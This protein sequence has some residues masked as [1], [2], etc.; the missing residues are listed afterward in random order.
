MTMIHI[1]RAQDDEILGYLDNQ[2]ANN[3]YYSA[4]HEQDTEGK[5]MLV[6]TMPASTDVA[7]HIEG[8]VR[9]L[10]Q[11]E[12]GGWMEFIAFEVVTIDD[13]KEVYALGVEEDLNKLK[14]IVPRRYESYTLKQYLQIATAGTQYTIGDVEYD[15]FRTLTLDDYMGGYDF[16]R[17]VA[18][19]FDVELSYRVEVSGNKIVKRYIDVS[20]SMGANN[21]KEIVYG[22]DLIGIKKVEYSDRI[23]TSLFCI[24]PKKADGTRITTTVTDEDAFQRWNRNGA[25]LT[26]RYE[27]EST[28]E[29]MTIAQLQAYGT[30]ELKKRIDSIDEYLVTGVSIEEIYPNEKVRLG[31]DV[32]V[33]NIEYQ[34]PLYADARVLSV[35]RSLIDGDEKDY[36]IGNVFAHDVDDVLAT[37]RTMQSQYGLRIIKSVIAPAGNSSIIWVKIDAA[38]G[39]EIA[40]TWNGDEWI[41]ASPTTPEQ[42]GAEP[43]IP[44]QPTPPLNPKL[45]DKWVDTSVE[46]MELK[47]YNGVEWQA[48]QGPRGQDGYTPVKGTDY[49]DGEAGQ[50]GTD[51]T[52]SYVWIRYSQNADGSAMTTSPANAKYIGVATSSTAIVPT[53]NLSYQWSLVKGTDG[54]PGET[55]PNGQTSYIHIKYSDNGTSFTANNG[56]TVGT[57]IGIYVDFVAADSMTFSAYTW[58]KVKGEQGI[59]GPTGSQGLQGIQ[60]YEGSQG[61]QG[62]VGANGV[63]SYTHIAYSTSPTGA[64]G[65]SIGDSVGATYIGI[66][67]DSLAQDSVNPSAY[68]WTLIKGSDGTQGLPGVK[69]D[70]G[71]TPYFHTAWATNSNG[72]LGFSTTVAT[73][74]TYIGTYTDNTAADSTDPSKYTWMLTKGETGATGSQGPI[75]N[76]GLQGVQGPTGNTGIKGDTGANGQTSYTHIAYSTNATGGTGF[77]VSD[78]TG[79]TYIGM[80][81]DF[82]ATD[83]AD[84]AKYAWSLIKGADGG[85]GVAGPTGPTGQTPYLH[86][87]YSTNAT[88]TTGFS[89]TDPVG[90]THIGTY[91]DFISTD[92]STPSLYSWSLIKGDTG[93]KGD[94]GSIGPIG[95]TGPQGSQGVVGPT[96]PTGATL[97]T[98]IKYAD[99]PTTGMVDTPTGKTYI[100]LAYNKSISTE[101]SVYTD[102]SW[103]L[104][105][106][107]IGAEG[108]KGTTG[109]TLYTWIKYADTIAGAGLTDLPADKEY[110]GI[111]YN[112]SVAAESTI[113]TDYTWSLIQGP[114]G[115]VGPTGPIG[116]QGQQGVIGPTGPNG[117]TLYTWIKYADTPTTGMADVPTGKTYIGL[118]YNKTTATETGTYS[119][120]AWSLIKGDIGAEG[121]KGTTGATL[122]TWIKYADTVAG[123]GLVDVP[124]GKKYIGIAYNKSVAAES[125][126]AADYSWSLIQGDTGAVGPQGPL[127]PQGVI[128]PAGPQGVPSYT[129]IK[130]ATTPTTGMA[131][132]PTGKDYIGL[133]H[134]KTIA[135]ESS[136]YADYTWSLIKGATGSEGP[137]GPGGAPTYTWVKYADTVT[138]GG[139]SDSPTGKRFLGL[140]YNKS[141]AAESVIPTDYQWSPLYDNITVGGKNLLLKSGE[142]ITN[143]SYPIQTYAITEAIANTMEVTLSFKGTLGRTSWG[144]YNSGGGVILVTLL[145]ADKGT[146]GIFRKTFNWTVGAST[147][148]VLH[149]YPMPSTTAIDSTIEWI[150]LEKGNVA[151]D[152]TPSPQDVQIQLDDKPA[153]AD[154]EAVQKSIG[155]QIGGMVETLDG[156]ANQSDLNTVNGQ[157][158]ITN[159]AIATQTQRLSTVE[160]TADGVKS[161]ITTMQVTLNENAEVIASVETYMNFTE[162]GLEIGKSDS[163]MKVN[164][165]NTEIQFNDNGATVAY[166]NGQ[167]LY[168]TESEVLESLIIGNHKFD[169]LGTSTIITWVGGN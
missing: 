78:P 41:A 35:K 40:H 138:G 128:G 72:T 26:E 165:T 84:P 30:K 3:L 131:D 99:S 50:D 59:A 37:F 6:V 97:Y 22:K 15:G 153:T 44:S 164:I 98:W 16:L 108:P 60:G 106:G 146:D 46:P 74:K 80:Y 67:V 157:L 149:V 168:I 111:A 62:P 36:V 151:T 127:G 65:F 42:V 105:K 73:A 88:G 77:S 56:E 132:T 38:N 133:A 19:E 101:S 163:D 64:T 116:P 28:D 7:Q 166:I 103:S 135:A 124:A 29:G 159:E 43:E 140:A 92:S 82:I 27:P 156:K 134:N 114:Q 33:I 32:R 10:A 31:D 102:Y 117:A 89:T 17:R 70:D 90:K 95:P 58:N 55:G 158:D 130:Y 112:K 109:A 147:N 122:Y 162:T 13:M 125:T 169:K 47:M 126:V 81:T 49:F 148:D 93:G 66:Y 161:S 110:I 129:W 142:P 167:K 123:V 136:V 24:G 100:G 18:N 154:L 75:G 143:Q 14:N 12:D 144:I 23:V 83:S 94:T 85:Q 52:S 118:A 20:I 5:N 61:I 155:D 152:W 9:L 137:A 69:G 34:P 63:S 53:S 119:D 86:I 87:A 79:K 139:I 68:A 71:L 1:L 45:G 2:S 8:R 96:G 121:P 160:K 57:Y 145:P 115:V 107:D 150:K 39:L 4:I 48:V 21:R 25:H 54:V 51:G 11:S 141:V 113:A 104:I 91:T 76:T 120:Y